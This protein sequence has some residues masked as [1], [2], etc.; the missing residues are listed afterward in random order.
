MHKKMFKTKEMN[1]SYLDKMLE[2]M[3]ADRKKHPIRWMWYDL[4][5]W[6]FVTLNSVRIFVK[7]LKR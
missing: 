1:K 5:G 7:K 6:Y 3:A 4:R 2:D